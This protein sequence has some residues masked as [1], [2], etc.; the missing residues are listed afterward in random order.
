MPLFTYKARDQKGKLVT[1]SA[2]ETSV[3]ALEHSLD[4]RGLIPIKIEE[5][6]EAFNF[7]KI[8]L[9]FQQ[10]KPEDKIVFTRQLATLFS[11]GIPFIK[12]LET[13]ASQAINEKMRDV[14]NQVRQDVEGGFSFANALKKHPTVFSDLYVNMIAAG[15]E[16]GVLDEILD[17]LAQMAEKEEE[18]R[19]KVKSS[20]LY[21]KFVVAAIVFAVFVMLFFV[22]PRF[23][24][25]YSKYGAE[26]PLPTR[27]LLG[28]SDNFK[29]YWYLILG[30]MSASYA[31]FRAYIKTEAGRYKWETFLITAPIFGALNL[32]VAMSRFARTFGTLFK[33]GI[34]ILQTIDIVA[35]A[36]GNVVIAN[37]MKK[38][39]EDVQAGS[40]L[41]DSMK[42]FSVFP[43]I[44]LQMIEIGE[45]SGNLD[46]MLAKV[47]E[48]FDQEV[49]YGIKNLITALGPVLLLFLFGMV[50]F[51]ALAVF[52]PMWDIMKIVRH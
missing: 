29:K 48:Y 27:M 1:G 47:S 33:S 19:A 9:F 13:L 50:L 25:L 26:L 44:I 3:I 28:M 42:Q 5:T 23:T 10:I 30:V 40:G 6:S 52:L 51:L 39:R 37:L 2:N 49:E 11:A 20:T 34:P 16:G 32:K 4:S 45:E 38:I 14:I 46:T 36:I 24:A 17:R 31:G 35:N 43:P 18:I 12:S 41:A 15:E 22:V 21:P 8:N 7:D